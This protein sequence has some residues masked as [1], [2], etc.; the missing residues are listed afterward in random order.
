M[1]PLPCYSC[2]SLLVYLSLLLCHILSAK[3]NTRGDTVRT[4][5]CPIGLV[6]CVVV[7]IISFFIRP[8][9]QF[10][11]VYG[12]LSTNCTNYPNDQSVFF[13]TAPVHPHMTR[14]AIYLA[15]FFCTFVH[16]SLC[17]ISVFGLFVRRKT[18]LVSKSK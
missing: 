18:K 16:V 8:C 4:H 15:F 9:V 6:S 12:Q 3:Y 5:C 1:T 14:L 17:S 2:I 7:P 11:C 13:I 10:C